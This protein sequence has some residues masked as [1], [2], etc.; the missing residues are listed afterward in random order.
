MLISKI[1]LSETI[2]DYCSNMLQIP[3]INM[4]IKT[5]G[6]YGSVESARKVFDE[7]TQEKVSDWNVMVSGYWRCGNKDEA[8]K[9]FDM[10]FESETNVVSWTVMITGFAKLKDLERARWCFDRMGEK[11]VTALLGMHA[12]CKDILSARRIF[13][14]LGA[15]R[16]LCCFMEL[17]DCWFCS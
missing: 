9:L 5:S 12:K 16:N 1:N 8:C 11:S 14:K 4:S 15:E 6:N 3:D 13:N 2:L 17:D 10:M 7:I